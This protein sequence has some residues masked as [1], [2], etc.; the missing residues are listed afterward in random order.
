MS[1]ERLARAEEEIE[2]LR[3]EAILTRAILFSVIRLAINISPSDSAATIAELERLFT[4]GVVSSEIRPD[5]LAHEG[6]ERI[7]DEFRRY[8][9]QV[10]S[11]DFTKH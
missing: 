9:R 2:R 7:I 11:H 8:V 1:D 4:T 10:F 5:S 6:A 3:G